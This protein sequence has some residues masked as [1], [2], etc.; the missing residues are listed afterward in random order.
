MQIVYVMEVIDPVERHSGVRCVRRFTYETRAE[1]WARYSE[2]IRFGFEAYVEEVGRLRGAPTS[3]HGHVARSSSTPVSRAS[4]DGVAS[5]P[6]I[7]AVR[8]R[9]R[10]R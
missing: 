2:A 5:D 10:R 8:S 7:P 4:R 1:A 9:S 3:P 6:V